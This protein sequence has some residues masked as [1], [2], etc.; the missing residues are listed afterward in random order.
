MSS[1]DAF[2]DFDAGICLRRAVYVVGG[3]FFEDCAYLGGLCTSGLTRGS[4]NAQ[5]R[6]ADS[7]SYS[8]R[9]WDA[10]DSQITYGR[11]D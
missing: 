8:N 4:F 2:I 5:R 10:T 1:I 11:S 6:V 3:T 7:P 9:L